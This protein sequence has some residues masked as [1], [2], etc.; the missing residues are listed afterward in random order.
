MALDP[1]T[2]RILI[3]N[4]VTGR[5]FRV[6]SYIGHRARGW[7]FGRLYIGQDG[8][9]VRAWPRERYAE[10]E[11]IDEVIIEKKRRVTYVLKVRA[12]VGSFTGTTVDITIG[13][14]NILAQL[15]SCGYRV[16]DHN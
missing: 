9:R 16:S 3:M 10:R 15:R 1:T 6:G 2:I 7:P 5:S 13:R 8:I 4:D 11:S 14:N 12:A